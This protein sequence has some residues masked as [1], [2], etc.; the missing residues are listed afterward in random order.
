M[1]AKK[2]DE[3]IVSQ[4][5]FQTQT[6][7]EILEHENLREYLRA[8]LLARK[9]RRNGGSLRQ[10]ARRAGFSSPSLL[11]M[12]IS[13]ERS[14]TEPTAEKLAKALQLTG[15]RRN[16]FI[17]LG[18]LEAAKTE[19]EKKKFRDILMQ[20]KGA[21]DE[22]V[23]EVRN[24]RFLTE[25]YYLVVYVLVGQRG[26]KYSPSEISS[27]LK[28]RVNELQVRRALQDLE[29]LGLIK[30][31]GTRW[32]QTHQAVTTSENNQDVALYVYHQRMAD[33]AKESLNQPADLREF[34][35]ITISIPRNQIPWVKDKLRTLRKEI[36]E[37]LSQFDQ[38]ANVYQCNMQLFALTEGLEK[39]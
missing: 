8:E 10:L 13:G 2:R 16:Y 26:F 23:L 20:I 15:R 27:K 24:Y 1:K 21:V 22:T 30:K 7:V 11:S 4:E 14:L 36:N 5:Q 35:G 31:V 6:S 32:Q 38:P 28:G 18:K 34:N 17:T 9:V 25:W 37:H 33:L 12:V 29:A 19:S 3:L 39:S